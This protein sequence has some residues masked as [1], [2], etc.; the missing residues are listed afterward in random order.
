MFIY[1]VLDKMDNL[2]VTE[3]FLGTK[4]RVYHMG[5]IRETVDLESFMTYLSDI[6]KNMGR[7]VTASLFSRL[8]I[9]IWDDRRSDIP[10]NIYSCSNE[11]CQLTQMGIGNYAG[12]T[13]AGR[14]LI[15]INDQNFSAPKHQYMSDV[16]SHEMGHW[17]QFWNDQDVKYKFDYIYQEWLRIRGKFATNQTNV[18]E[19]VAEDFRY[20]FGSRGAKGDARGDVRPFPYEVE[21]LKD[22]MKIWI[23]ST[24]FIK[25]LK[26][27]WLWDVDNVEYKYSD[28]D[29]DYFGL[30]FRF[31][32]KY[33]SWLEIWYWIDRK[34]IW[35]YSNNSWVPYRS[36]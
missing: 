16:L 35:V 33:F 32:H 5:D 22:L 26:S 31:F 18:F 11:E 21:G 3:S 8:S 30:K 14:D 19:L 34:N 29:S 2:Y 12:L 28:I 23:P 36:F 20:F 4:V 10:K 13:W 24:Q 25:E 27:V 9:E 1:K 7:Y 15:Q 17:F 6:Q